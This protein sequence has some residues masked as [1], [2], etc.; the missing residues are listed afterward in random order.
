[1]CIICCIGNRAQ[2]P[3]TEK[4]LTSGGGGNEGGVFSAMEEVDKQGV[5]LGPGSRRPRYKGDDARVIIAM[6]AIYCSN[7]D[8]Q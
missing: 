4:G 3:K 2:T 7:D 5:S 1:M 8:H 6:G